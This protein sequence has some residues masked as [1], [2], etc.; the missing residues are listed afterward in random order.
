MVIPAAVA[1]Q[2]APAQT[3]ELPRTRLEQRVRRTPSERVIEM[4][5]PRPNADRDAL[6]QARAEL[7]AAY[8]ARRIDSRAYAEANFRNAVALRL[9]E[10]S[11]RSADDGEKLGNFDIQNLMNVYNRSNTTASTVTK[12]VDDTANAVIGKV[13]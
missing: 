1:I 10:D 6:L 13:G 9:L 5:R 8:R 12:K 3:A 11:L 2:L 7:D 4:Q